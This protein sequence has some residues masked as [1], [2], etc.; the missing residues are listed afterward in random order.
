MAG[1]R[2]PGCL[3]GKLGDRGGGDS[4]LRDACLIETGCCIG[5]AG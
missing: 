5:E 2:P 1:N 4:C 3:C